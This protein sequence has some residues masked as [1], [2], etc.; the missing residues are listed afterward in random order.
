METSNNVTDLYRFYDIDGRL[1]YVGISLNAA[2]RA[3]QHRAEK[4]WWPDVARMDV[5]RHS[6]RATALEA[7]RQAIVDERPRHNVVHA[8][9]L[10]SADRW[11]DALWV[12]GRGPY[13]SI[14][15]CNGSTTVQLYETEHDAQTAKRRIDRGACGSHCTRQHE[16]VRT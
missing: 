5:E 2:M 10:S 15:R 14:S 4:S 11:P 1:L 8:K 3:A 13:A 6:D 16:V 12:I 7:E 9:S